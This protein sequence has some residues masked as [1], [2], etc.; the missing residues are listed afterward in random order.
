[1]TPKE[2]HFLV[3]Q[4]YRNLLDCRGEHLEHRR[5]KYVQVYKGHSRGIGRLRIGT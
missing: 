2:I 1:M 4:T 5:G 3:I